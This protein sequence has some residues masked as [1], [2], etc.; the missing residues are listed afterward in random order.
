[1]KIKSIFKKILGP[2]LGL[3][4]IFTTL[5]TPI[6]STQTAYAVPETTETQQQTDQQATQQTDQQADQQAQDTESQETSEAD[7]NKSTCYDN[8]GGL[9]WLICPTTGLLANIIDTLYSAIEGFLKIS[10]LSTDNT[11]PI[12]LVWQYARDITNIV[13]VIFLLVIVWSQLTGV[14]ISNYGIKKTLPRIIIAAILVN[15]SYFICTLA[16]DVSNIIGVSVKNFLVGIAET[17]AGSAE[18][19]TSINFSD[20]FAGLVAGGTIA[21]IA[22]GLSGG[23]GHLLWMFLGTV[24]AGAVSIFV[25][26]LTVAMRQA[27]V[28]ILVMISPLAFVCYLLPNTE[29]WFEKWKSTLT[30]MLVFYP[31]FAGLFGACQLAGWAITASA[32]DNAFFIILGLAV[33]VLPLF[34]AAKL[35]KMSG[36]V[37]GQVSGAL[38]KATDPLRR[39]ARKMGLAQGEMY[40]QRY[41]AN[42]FM[43]AAGLRRYMDKRQRL[44]DLNTKSNLEARAALAESGAQKIIGTGG[45]TYDPGNPNQRIRTTVWTRNAK[46]AMNQTLEAQTAAMDT[47]HILGNYSNFHNKTAADRALNTQGGVNFMEYT[48]AESAA[49]ADNYADIDWLMGKYDGIRKLGAGNYQ[50]D[51]YITGAAGALKSSGEALV[52]GQIISKA[53][54]NESK[55]RQALGYVFAKYGYP[56]GDARDAYV[57]YYV[58]DDGLATYAPDAN[59]NR[60]LVKINEKGEIDQKNGRPEMGPGEFLKYHPEVLQGYKKYELVPDGKGGVKKRFYFDAKDQD[61]KFVTRVYRD[62]GPSMKEALAGWDMPIQDPINGLYGILSGINPGDIKVEGLEGVGLAKLSTTLGRAMMSSKYSEKATFAGPMYATSVGAR[63]VKDFVHQNIERFDNIVKTAK[64]SKFNTQ[65]FAEL[66]QLHQ[67][68][69]PK[70]WDYML[71][72]EESLMSRRNVNGKFLE[73]TRI[74]L[75]ENGNPKRNA[76]GK[77]VT[78]TVPADQ[79]TKEELQNT[80]IVKMINPT[81]SRMATM[82]T[83]ITQQTLDNQKPGVAEEWVG[84]LN[85]LE[86]IRDKLGFNKEHPE[87]KDEE[88]I[89]KYPLLTN[90]LAEQTSSDIIIQARNLRRE[91]NPTVSNIPGGGPINRTGNNSLGGPQGNN[92]GNPTTAGAPASGQTYGNDHVHSLDELHQMIDRARQGREDRMGADPIFTDEQRAA[93]AELQHELDEEYEAESRMM[94][95]LDPSDNPNLQI[96]I[97]DIAAT[98]TDGEDFYVAA[99][100][101][102]IDTFTITNDEHLRDLID[103]FEN[104]HTSNFGATADEFHDYLDSLLDSYNYLG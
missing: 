68:M 53:A 82:M 75:D 61:G 29:K 52:L 16:V 41:I 59:G 71:F 91:L 10:P 7:E 79:A 98:T 95:D 38:S 57:G 77:I 85:D 60:E 51:H 33:R 62:D 48:R 3:I 37:L 36:T 56:K 12:Y 103:D 67:L 50:Y 97:N 65:D 55:R 13:F 1:M 93:D 5:L 45:E 46:N 73:G 43:P 81:A 15:L 23:L 76:K 31:M 69:D 84:L 18:V 104:F 27:V 6:V 58:N 86:L 11:S 96:R 54:A 87:L 22:I 63:L 66:N 101:E 44:R 4:L 102:L 88:F 17:A 8:A 34:M 28:A 83:R 92:S 90:P 24:L 30:S 47:H 35:L 78:V 26:F 9:G 64:P 74:V 42:S 94:G 32:G 89:K 100:N 19:T 39:N 2:F 80:I 70:N 49:I 72:D 21:G 20:V 14:G 99:M 40:K 25:G